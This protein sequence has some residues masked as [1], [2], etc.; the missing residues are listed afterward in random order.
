MFSLILILLVISVVLLLL[1]LLL[2]LLSFSSML[3]ILNEFMRIMLTL[4][5]LSRGGCGDFECLPVDGLTGL[6]VFFLDRFRAFSL[7]CSFILFIAS[8]H[9]I[10]KIKAFRLKHQRHRNR[11]LKN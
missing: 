3:F 11:N 7:S 4:I 6:G 2:L 8:K 9:F 5:F 1:L 10:M